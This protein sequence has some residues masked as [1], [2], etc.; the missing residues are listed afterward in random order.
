MQES[1]VFLVRVQCRRKESSRSLSHL[2]MSFLFVASREFRLVA[3]L[4]CL[5]VCVLHL[6]TI[7]TPNWHIPVRGKQIIFSF[8]RSCGHIIRQGYSPQS[9]IDLG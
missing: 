6:T 8:L 2:L 1:I 4:V 3:L 9:V 5:S 7:F